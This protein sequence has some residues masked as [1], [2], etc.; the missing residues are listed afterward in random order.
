MRS[1]EGSA[2]VARE[3]RAR[4]ERCD[5]KRFHLHRALMRIRWELENEPI[6]SAAAVRAIDAILTEAGYSRLEIEEA[7]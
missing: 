7:A 6:R 1:L 3:L 5:A 4:L 2:E